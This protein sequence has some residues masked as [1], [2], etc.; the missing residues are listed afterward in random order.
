[1][2]LNEETVDDGDDDDTSPTS[3][4]ASSLP[5]TE[6]ALNVA[7]FTKHFKSIGKSITI[8]VETFKGENFCGLATKK[9]RPGG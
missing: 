2:S 9:L 1:M 7:D 6:R 8:Y 3:S 5:P 4:V